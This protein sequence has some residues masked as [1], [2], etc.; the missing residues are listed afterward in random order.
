[1]K[2]LDKIFRF[3][4]GI[5][6]VGHKE[7]AADVP[8]KRIPWPK[9]LTI[10]MSQHIGAPSVPC[11]KVGDH[12]A[13]YQ[14]IADAAGPVSSNAHAPLAGVVKAIAPAPTPVGRIAQAITIEVD[15]EGA[16]VGDPMP[17]LDWEA[18][19]PA[20]LVARVREAGIVG[21]GGAG[22][23]T[24][25]KLTPPKGKEIDTVIIN[26]AE[27]EPYLNGD[28][29]LMMERAPDIWIGAQ[30]IRRAVGAKR[31]VVAIEDNKPR[32]IESMRGAIGEADGEIAVLPHSY[33]QGSEKHVIFSVT[34]RTV[35]TGKLP[36][37]V[38]CLVENV[39]TAVAICRAVCQGI[40][41]VMRTVTLAGDAIARPCNL[42]APVGTSVADLVAVAD[43]F[44]AK[45]AKAICG[46][47]MMGF[48][49][50][51]IDVPITK[52]TSGL[53]FLTEERV[54]EFESNPC[55]GCGRCIRACPM[56]LMPA[57]LSQAIEA[58]DLDLARKLH[59]MNCFEC[60]SC[61]YV[62]PAHRPLVQ[63]NRR[64]KAVI[65]AKIREE[66]AREAKAREAAA[67]GSKQ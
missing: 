26:G 6:T 54:F 53:L 29:R 37:D 5:H 22:F 1:M 43:G 48:A 65:G 36:A 24:A 28:N 44:R 14:K 55:I 58:N 32:A 4:G 18:A 7:E 12:V 41:T 33:P 10:S 30:I 50:A 52:T 67:G 31:I 56:G 45:P 60:G 2:F 19:E 20:A 13:R 47:P 51:T 57:E 46:G 11:V 49:M 66:K 42:V 8:L 59:V 21:A 17:P 25:V 38:G 23:P 3:A 15:A 9:T 16:E 39:W 63:H 34:G 35:A 62:C 40:P 61:A 64:A 27:C